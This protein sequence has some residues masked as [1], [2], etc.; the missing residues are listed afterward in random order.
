MTDEQ[1]NKA[2]A[3]LLG[4]GD[5]WQDKQSG[6]WWGSM[7]NPHIEDDKMPLP[8]YC[9]DPA[10]WAGLF[11]EI[12]ARGLVPAIAAFYEE[13]AYMATINVGHD[14]ACYIAS[15]ALPG[16]AL[17]LAALKAYGAEG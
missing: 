2:V 7:P 12:K 8:D 10:A 17:A 11:I 13:N 5:W 3:G 14:G 9:T 4:W 6:M 15:D 16:R 1:I